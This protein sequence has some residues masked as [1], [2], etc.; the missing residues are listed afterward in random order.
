MK[1]KN[2]TLQTR[3]KL[4]ASGVLLAGLGSAVAIYLAAGDV[5]ENALGEYAPEN[6]KMFLHDLELYGGKAN[7]LANELMTW[8]DGLWH[9]KTLAYTV[10][11]IAVVISCGLFYV[12]RQLPSDAGPDDR[13]DEH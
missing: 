8:F 12:A 7:L 4:F 13:D 6:S 11:C 9:G 2:S 1:W 3:L 5:A 10:A